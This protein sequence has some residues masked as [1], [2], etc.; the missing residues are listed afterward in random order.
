MFIP[1]PAFFGVSFVYL[2]KLYSVWRVK[3]KPEANSIYGKMANK[4]D[5]DN[6]SNQL[7]VYY[8]R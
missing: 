1:S 4:T 8:S 6:V 2:Y 3:E 5:A 7:R